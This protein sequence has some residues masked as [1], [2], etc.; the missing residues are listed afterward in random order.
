MCCLVGTP[1]W[2]LQK[3]WQALFEMLTMEKC[4]G[5]FPCDNV[6]LKLKPFLWEPT[7]T[8]YSDISLLTIMAI[9]IHRKFEYLCPF[10]RGNHTCTN[11][12][13]LRSVEVM[14]V[15]LLWSCVE[16]LTLKV[17]RI[18]EFSMIDYFSVSLADICIK[19]YKGGLRDKHLFSDVYYV[20]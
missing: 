9:P 17:S 19:V 15:V 10:N 1:T 14:L 18:N 2:Q 3:S 11:I 16:S 13:V 4:I 7:I 8:W 6:N 12:L 5:P 20:A